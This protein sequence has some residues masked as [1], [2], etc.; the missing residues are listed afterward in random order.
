MVLCPGGRGGAI[1]GHGL[2]HQRLAPGPGPIED[3][4]QKLH[5]YS[6]LHT[7]TGSLP[8]EKAAHPSFNIPQMPSLITNPQNPASK[9][10]CQNTLQLQQTSATKEITAKVKGVGRAELRYSQALL[11]LGTSLLQVPQL[12]IHWYELL[13]G[14]LLMSQ[15]TFLC[16][17]HVSNSR[18]CFLTSV[19]HRFFTC[20]ARDP[21]GG[22]CMPK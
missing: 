2:G 14:E 12:P 9:A 21:Q 7:C 8:R 6:S 15:N 4:P 20:L 22:V 17:L 5:P 3:P 13:A 18:C 19:S 10:T 11:G 1:L 16:A